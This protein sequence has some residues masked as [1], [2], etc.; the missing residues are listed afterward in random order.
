MVTVPPGIE[1]GVCF[2]LGRTQPTRSTCTGHGHFASS[3][4]VGVS[5]SGTLCQGN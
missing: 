3:L 5:R 1:V 4:Q 2:G